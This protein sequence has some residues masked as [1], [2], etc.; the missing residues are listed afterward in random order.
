MTEELEGKVKYYLIKDVA[1]KTLFSR[2]NDM[3]LEAREDIESFIRVHAPKAK[4]CN[5]KTDGNLQIRY[6]SF[7]WK[8][9]DI[10]HI[11]D[12]AYKDY[13]FT[14]DGIIAIPDIKNKLGKRIREEQMRFLKEVT[15]DCYS[16]WLEE[17]SPLLNWEEFDEPGLVYNENNKTYILV[18][19][20]Q[21]YRPPLGVVSISKER[22]HEILKNI[23]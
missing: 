4:L 11:P 7:E 19:T 9:E 5:L 15:L 1:I 8:F 16:M 18:T 21:D 14:D 6:L 2:L 23:N 3:Q 13:L 20:S 17:I 10:K 22:S 12:G